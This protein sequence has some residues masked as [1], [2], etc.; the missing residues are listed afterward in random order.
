MLRI[1]I[2]SIFIPTLTMSQAKTFSAAVQQLYFNI[3]IQNSSVDTILSQ[4]SKVSTANSISTSLSSLSVNFDMEIDRKVNKV[5]HLFKFNKSPLLYIPIDNGYI[6]ITISEFDNSKKI[7]DID[8][9]CEFL[10]KH[11]AKRFF[12][13]LVKIFSLISQI[14]KIAPDDL[15]SGEYA[16]FSSRSENIGRIKDVTFFFGKSL[17]TNKYE[18]RFIPYNEFME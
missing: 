5:S 10:N 11:D 16:E 7:V 4:F 2:I 14:Q 15:N 18:V 12:N 13:E 6:K 3:D 1:L 17:I 9:C 8:W